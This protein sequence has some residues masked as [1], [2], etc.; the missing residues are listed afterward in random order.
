M[1]G[2]EDDTQVWA[3]T[4]PLPLPLFSP[5]PSAMQADADAEH[6]PELRGFPPGYFLIRSLATGR[7]LS[8]ARSSAA[9]GAP[10]VLWPTLESSLVESARAR[11]PH[12]RAPR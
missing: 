7:L 5:P 3:A 2:A 6:V 4:R 9:D 8:V 1:A 12:A 11:R 10:L